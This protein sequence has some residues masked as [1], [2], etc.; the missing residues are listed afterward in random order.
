M[1]NLSERW[2]RLL[3]RLYPPDFRDEM[4]AAVVEAY[5][6]RACDAL[7][8]GGRIRLIALWAR[9]FVDSL[10]N[11]AAERA[12]PAALWRRAGDWGRDIELVRRRLARSPI[13]AATTIGT[14]TIGLGM[15]AVV[16]TAAQKILI[17]PMPYKDPGD[18]YYVW[19][20][21]GSIADVPRGSLAGTDI[22]EL[23]KTN[24][25]IEAA[26]GLQPFLGGVFSLREGAEPMEIA[27]TWTSPNL[28]HL[29]GVTPA[30]GRSFAPDEIAPSFVPGKIGPA[31]GQVIILTHQLW[32]R[33]GADPSIVGA[34]VRLQGRPFTVIGV[35]PPDFTF[36]RNDAAA[37]PQRVDA[38][39]PIGDLARTNPRDGGYAGIIRARHGASPDAVAAAVASVG[40]AIDARDFN[41]RGLKL[42]PVG[43]KADVISRIRP[44]LVVLGAAGLVLVFMLMLN[45]ASVLIARAAQRQ[46]E[47]AVSRAL[48]ANTAAI[49]RST[50]LEGGLLGLAGGALGALVAIWGARSLVALAPLDLP[51]REAIAIDSSIAVTVIAIG[52][53]LGALAA[54]APAVWSARVSLSSL[55]AGSAVR[56]GGGQ[57]RLR[58]SLIVAQVALSLVL[59][60]SGALVMRSFERLLR[61]DPGFNPDGL[62]TVRV[63]TPP[64]FFPKMS[65]AIAF[66]ERVQLALAAIPGVTGASAA[67]ALP[68]TATAFFSQA[69]IT[70][71]GAPGNTGNAE[72]DRALIDRIFVRPNYIE[73]MGMRLQAGR[74][75]T[76]P[77]PNGVTEA[78]IDT[79][80]ARRFF[81]EGNA[82]GAQV[83]MGELSL[84]IIGVVNQARL[85]EVHADGRPQVLV[86]NTESFGSRPLF[87]VMRTT[88]EPHSLLPEVQSAVHRIDPRVAVGDPRAMDDIVQASLS[89]QAIG[90]TLIS[91]FA[92]GALLLSAMGLFGVVS[93]SV[94]R[95]RHELAI[96][97]ALG[98]DH[99]RIL[100]LALKEGALLVVAGLLIGA[101]GI[102]IA[103]RLIR[104]LLVGVSPSDPPTLLAAALGLLIVTMA[105]CYVPARRALRIEP[106]QLLRHE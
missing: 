98:A 37:P 95:R 43:L 58:R 19:R 11:G 29:L 60:S 59:L 4:G 102:Y 49:V 1:L 51:R 27:V 77:P 22:V 7:K 55:L 67:S 5:M 6:D 46:H 68:L 89:P 99:G 28:F 41:S 101:P 104:G 74:T 47:V 26:A 34:D 25:I 10:R 40:R 35:A 100:R 93:G 33:L 18:L 20:D 105:T 31:P 9:A 72:R 30:L 52:A 73:A 63:R 2:F 14:L 32:K 91:A 78:L 44:A 83:R 87:F 80:I 8:T 88:R 38:Y 13:F 45:L 57:G 62:F 106:A 56:G 84:T 96:R 24:G 81:P 66:H 79:A 97:L 90:A 69:T 50:L 76:E 103:N 12:R 42:Y 39:I 82:I 3:R 86:R 75:F 21:Y 61:A 71:P 15:F 65:D 17:D 53:L 85:Y 70:V 92:V 23:Q 64:E 54:A 36:V 94:T 16:Y 48:G